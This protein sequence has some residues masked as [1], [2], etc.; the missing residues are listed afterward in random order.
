MS[1]LTN[2]ELRPCKFLIAFVVTWVNFVRQIS[3]VV[4]ETDYREL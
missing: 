3:Y 4:S 2:N 1:F